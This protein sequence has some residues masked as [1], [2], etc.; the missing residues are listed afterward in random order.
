MNNKGFFYYL[1]I[2]TRMSGFKKT[3]EKLTA[4]ET[5]PQKEETTQNSNEINEITGFVHS[6]EVTLL[7]GV[8]KGVRGSVNEFHSGRYD[9]NKLE[10]FYAPQSQY[11]HKT[12]EEIISKIPILYRLKLSNGQMIDVSVDFITEIV[13]YKTGNNKNGTLQLGNLVSKFED[14]NNIHKIDLNNTLTMQLSKLKLE[15]NNINDLN[16]LYISNNLPGN[17]NKIIAPIKLVENLSKYIV[18]D[19]FHFDN[20]NTQDTIEI[21]STDIVDT[22]FMVFQGEFIGKFGNVVEIFEPQYL[23]QKKM[24]EYSVSQNQIKKDRNGL[25]QIIKGKFKS[26][27]LYNQNEYDYTPPHLLITLASNGLTITESTYNIGTASDPKFI[28]RQI[29]PNDVF[30]F[31][32]KLKDYGIAEVKKLNQDGTFNA[33][34]LYEEEINQISFSDILETEPGFK[35]KYNNNNNYKINKEENDII[36][37]EEEKQEEEN[38]IPD[39]TEQNDYGDHQEQKEEPKQLKIKTD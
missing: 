39:E 15:K 17:T 8:H 14:I 2:V 10:S 9:F 36:I 24:I 34:T 6:N 26:D 3:L 11:T 16:K 18:D 28:T 21:S 25:V 5:L 12:G 38:D 31:D 35:W 32:V 27:K 33:T 22:Y 30:Y 20:N 4:K 29:T 13:V 7:K 23:I 37:E 1:Q 19:E